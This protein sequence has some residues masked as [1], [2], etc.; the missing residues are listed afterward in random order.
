[1]IRLHE[2]EPGNPRWPCRLGELTRKSGDV[3]QAVGWLSRASEIEPG[4]PHVQHLRVMLAPFLPD[5]SGP[6]FLLE[7]LAKPS[8]PVSVGIEAARRLIGSGMTRP[9]R[10]SLISI[11]PR[12]THEKDAREVRILLTVIDVI[13]TCRSAVGGV[14]PLVGRGPAVFDR[15]RGSDAA[16]LV[17]A[18]LDGSFGG[19]PVDLIQAMLIPL[20]VNAIYLFD[21]NRLLHLAGNP[22]LGRDYAETLL[23][24]RRRLKRW[25]V[26]RLATIGASAGGF[27]A[28]RYGLD[29]GVERVLGFGA[30]TTLHQGVL[31]DDGHVGRIKKRLVQYVPDMIGPIRPR[32]VESAAGP[33]IDLYFGSEV[34]LD[35]TQAEAI[36]DLDN[37]RLVSVEGLSRHAVAGEMLLRGEL[38]GVIAGVFAPGPGMQ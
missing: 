1:M 26:R 12:A 32:L 37:V 27:A 16:A 30:P 22:A 18:G 4:D 6:E 14:H 3:E 5:L 20:G 19:V 11:A 2:L 35:R 24:L 21:P 25:G 38:A 17:F 33:L 31:S 23:A 34:V 9:A 15:R 36:G 29:L 13:S 10:E 8:V 7:T 28:M